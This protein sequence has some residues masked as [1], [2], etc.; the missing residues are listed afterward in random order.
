MTPILPTDHCGDRRW[1]DAITAGYGI[2]WGALCRFRA[3]CTNLVRGKLG[4]GSALGLTIRDILN[5]CPKDQVVRSHARG[6]VAC[7]K[8][9]KTIGY[10]L[11]IGKLPSPSVSE[12]APTIA[13]KGA[14]SCFVGRSDPKPARFRARHFGPESDERIAPSVLGAVDVGVGKEYQQG[15]GSKRDGRIGVHHLSLLN[16]LG[17]VAPRGVCR[18]REAFCCPNYTI[19]AIGLSEKQTMRLATGLYA[20]LRDNG[21]LREEGR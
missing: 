12:Y 4:I 1:L 14:I 7:V 5:V 2:A 8:Y 15:L 16:R 20:F 17:G 13:A 10:L 21:L 6:V 11:L 9:P 3:N 18:T 19:M